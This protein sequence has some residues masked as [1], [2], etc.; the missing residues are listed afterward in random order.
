M[1]KMK[2]VFSAEDLAGQGMVSADELSDLKE[3]FQDGVTST[4][5][6]KPPSGTFG[7]STEQ[8]CNIRKWY[9]LARITMPE[10]KGSVSTFDFKWPVR[11]EEKRIFYKNLID[12]DCENTVLHTT[13]SAVKDQLNSSPFGLA[14]ENQDRFSLTFQFTFHD[15]V[16]SKYGTFDPTVVDRLRYGVKTD[17]M[18]LVPGMTVAWLGP[19]DYQWYILEGFKFSK[20]VNLAMLIFLILSLRFFFGRWRAGLIYCATLLVAAIWMFGLKGFVGSSFDVLSSGLF[21]M[22][23][24]SCLEDFLFISAEQVRGSS[25]KKSIRLMILPGFYTSVTTTIGFLSLTIS[26]IEVVRRMGLWAAFGAM[27]EWV[28]LFLILPC[29]L[30]HLKNLRRWVSTAPTKAFGAVSKFTTKSL[31]PWFSRVSLLIYPVAAIS[32]SNLDF[33]ESPHRVFPSDQEYSQ[34]ITELQASKGWIGSV[35]MIFDKQVTAVE[36]ENKIEQLLQDSWSRDFVV[37]HESP[38]S[39][40]NWM[41]NLKVLNLS[42][43]EGHFKISNL[44][45]QFVDSSD[46]SRAI[47]FVKDT[48][49]VPIQQLKMKVKGICGGDC[50]LGGEIVAYSDFAGSVPKTLMDSLLISLILVALIIGWLGYGLNKEHLS[51]KLILSSFW[52]PVLMIAFLGIAH[53]TLDFWK[54]IFASILVGL[55][56]DN[57][58]QYMFASKH[59]NLGSGI[60]TRGGASILTGLL[61]A[62]TSLIYLGSYFRSPRT[63]GLILCAGL[64]ASLVGDLWLLKGLLSAKDLKKN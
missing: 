16:G 51:L 20:Y 11:V 35:S 3:R 33:N 32:F 49:A 7:F 31:P 34:S 37:R 58:I 42:D 45:D 27:V 26:D 25:W 29:Y 61:M 46:L 36:M 14:A 12:L 60:S 9:S 23:G 55:T 28:I 39:I 15:A 38:Q 19:A 18:P 6:L 44:H 50:H 5:I 54:S 47:L 4:F 43:I 30:I 8:L 48:S 62:M 56:G 21:L 1:A 53:S 13:L 52:G 22:L 41:V 64:I 40:I 57:A 24:I 10:L 17:L 63:F 59:R 2:I